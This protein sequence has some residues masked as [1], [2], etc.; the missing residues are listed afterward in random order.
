MT[1]LL[2]AALLSAN[3]PG[4]VKPVVTV[5]YFENRTGNADLDVLRKGLSEMMVTDLVAWDGVT[6]VERDRLEAVLAELELQTSKAFDKS[7]TVK[8][9]KLI[10]AQYVVNGS[11]HRQVDALRVDAQILRVQDGKVVASASISDHQDR[12]F[13][14]EQ[15][16]VDKL[17]VAIDLRLKDTAQRKRAKAPNLDA[18]L[19]YSK[20]IDL[21]DRGRVEEA[22]AAMAAVVSKSPTFGMARE[23]KEYLLKKLKEAEERRKDAVT[24]AVVALGKLSETELARVKDFA[25]LD[26]AG[27]ERALIM[28]GLRAQFLARLLKQALSWRLDNPRVIK[29]GKEADA[30]KLMQ[31]WLE[32]ERRKLDEVRQWKP[33][34]GGYGSRD[35]SGA[36]EE[37]VKA[38]GFDEDVRL[39]PAEIVI[40]IAEFVVLGRLSDGKGFNVAPPLGVLSPREHDLAMG[41]LDEA[42]AAAEAAWKAAP[43]G[44]RR[45]QEHQLVR[46][47]QAKAELLEALRRDD[48][49]ASAWQRIMDLLPTSEAAVGAERRIKD[50]IEG[51][52]NSRRARAEF[53]ADLAGCEDFHVPEEISFHLRRGGLK[54][55]DGL[56]KTLEEKCLGAPGLA[57]AWQRFYSS[58]ASTAARAE[59]C[60]RA[61]RWHLMK[62]AYGETGPRGFDQYLT[63]DEGWCSYGLTE[64]T[65]PSL[66]RVSVTN[67]GSRDERGPFVGKG[68]QDLLEEA[69]GARGVALESGGTSHGGHQVFWLDPE[70]Q[71]DEFGVTVRSLGNDDRR[72]V[73]SKGGVLNVEEVI[74]PLF[75]T[76]RTGANPG[77]RKAVKTISLELAVEYGR[78]MDLYEDRKW[79]AAREAFEALSQKYPDVR[80][81]RVRAFLAAAKERKER[82]R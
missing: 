80:P 46:T 48:D 67:L 41:E 58:L 65:L 43:A 45:Y 22:Q 20:A 57:M 71:G 34:F 24:D 4:E 56:A 18:L 62:Y 69:F 14:I 13:D 17:T 26:P 61:K 40:D 21:S 29:L 39:E 77:P 66:V 32:N 3:A 64:D 63:R 81:A 72:L 75:A 59:D 8:V 5:L 28:R 53:E 31:A 19:Q 23:R 6:V 12:I 27:Q 1:S 15:Q 76:L 68:L 52:S 10:G 35:V 9:G 51:R 60:E 54:G 7:T 30:L 74:G 38:A 2:L 42:I 79:A 25:K 44:E 16:L 50:I 11:I 36:L 37:Q 73:M 47:L 82:S 55:L 49:A 78:A 70:L 33:G